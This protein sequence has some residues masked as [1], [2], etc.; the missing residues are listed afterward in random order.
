LDSSRACQVD[1]R[2]VAVGTRPDSPPT[3]LGLILAFLRLPMI[4]QI[5]ESPWRRHLTL[6]WALATCLGTWLG[7]VVVSELQR[8][9]Q[10]GRLTN[11]MIFLIGL[12]LASNYLH[13]RQ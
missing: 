1:A 2:L 7:M 5:P 12:T 6:G 4:A 9:W 11:A 10:F 3:A 13:S 8:G